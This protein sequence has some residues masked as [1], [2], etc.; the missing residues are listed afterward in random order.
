MDL[1]PNAL[2][3]TAMPKIYAPVDWQKFKL[4]RLFAGAQSCVARLKNDKFVV[5]VAMNNK[6]VMKNGAV[7]HQ[8]RT[9]IQRNRRSARDYDHLAARYEAC[10]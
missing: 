1:I 6:D 2:M 9:T 5:S 3:S 4:D 7:D 8:A 10:S